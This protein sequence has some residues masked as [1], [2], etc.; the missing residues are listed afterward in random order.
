MQ[1]Y[2]VLL[3]ARR[4]VAKDRLITAVTLALEAGIEATSR[5]NGSDIAAAWLHKF[6]LW[7]YVRHDGDRSE[8]FKVWV[9][10]KWGINFRPKEAARGRKK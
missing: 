7:G 2:D 4:L 1:W 5:S 8:G 3:A 9:L 10:T 6:H